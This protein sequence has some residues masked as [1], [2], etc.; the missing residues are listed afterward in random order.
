M[1][2]VK[3]GVLLG[4]ICGIQ[5]C[6]TQFDPPNSILFQLAFDAGT[7]LDLGTKREQFSQRHLSTVNLNTDE[8][9][10]GNAKSYFSTISVKPAQR[11]QIIAAYLKEQIVLIKIQLVEK[12]EVINWQLVKGGWFRS[13]ITI[14]ADKKL[15]IGD[16]TK[17]K[18]SIDINQSG[19]FP[20][21]KGID[22]QGK[23]VAILIQ[24][25]QF[26]IN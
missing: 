23:L 5:S 26:S 19:S 13:G 15:F 9:F 10:V 11:G 2:L 22:Q 16:S 6:T 14:P 1:G 7:Q 8:L 18:F 21:Y 25:R 24:L 3:L 4:I 12:T 20:I 17:P